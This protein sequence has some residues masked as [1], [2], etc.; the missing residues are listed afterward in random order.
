MTDGGMMD[1]TLTLQMIE[2]HQEYQEKLHRL[3]MEELSTEQMLT[4]PFSLPSETTGEPT[5]E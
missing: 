5:Q 1:S 4:L 2:E 3:L